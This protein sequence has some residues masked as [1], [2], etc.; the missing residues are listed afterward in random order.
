MHAASAID[1]KTLAA[2]DARLAEVEHT[3]AT[4]PH[5]LLLRSSTIAQYRLAG[6][7]L[8]DRDLCRKEQEVGPLAS[9]L[10]RWRRSLP[11][12]LSSE[13]CVAASHIYLRDIQLAPDLV[14]LC[15]SVR[16]QMLMSTCC[17]LAGHLA[18]FAATRSSVPFCHSSLRV[19]V[20]CG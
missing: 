9:N 5:V 1:D 16:E 11:P 12:T 8:T 3:S 15:I 17:R 20:I 10:A 14:T 4:S 7:R 18:G 13:P 2:R 6:P 19:L